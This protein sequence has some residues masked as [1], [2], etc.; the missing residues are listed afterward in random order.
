MRILMVEDDVL[1]SRDVTASLSRNGYLIECEDNGKAAWFKGDTEDYTAVILDLGLPGMDGLSI[2]KQWRESGR[3][4]P[5]LILTAR[6]NWTE[7]VEGIDAGADDYLAKPFQ[8]EELLARLRAIIRRSG[9][10]LSVIIN[11]GSLIIDTRDHTIT[12]HGSPVDITPLEFR[13]LHFLALHNDRMTSRVEL[14]D[15]L[16]EQY[17]ERESNSVDVLVWRLRK[18]LGSE[19]IVT[20]R[21]FG[22]R[23]STS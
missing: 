11:A 4:F 20:Q 17:S 8:M 22:Y 3:A 23:L 19:A 14:A 5:V 16:Y 18:K 2:L 10:Q 12:Q 13:C 6:G 7:R 15:H 9:G 21:R 1:I